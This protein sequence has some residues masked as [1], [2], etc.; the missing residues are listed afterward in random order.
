MDREGRRQG[1]GIDRM[2]RRCTVWPYCFLLDRSGARHGDQLHLADED[3][4][5]RGK[6]LRADDQTGAKA[7][8]SDW[9][10][11]GK[12]PNDVVFKS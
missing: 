6:C 7:N 2:Q 5:R 1:R 8:N 9:I 4:L 3:T 12:P 10:T 11:H